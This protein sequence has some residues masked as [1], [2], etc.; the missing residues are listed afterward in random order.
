MRISDWS[1]D[2]CSSDLIE[3][4]F[5]HRLERQRRHAEIAADR[6]PPA[7]FFQEVADERSGRRFS[8]GPGNADIARLGGGAG[9]QLDVAADRADRKSVVEGKS[10]YV[11]VGIGGRRVI[12]KNTNKRP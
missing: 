12:K 5:G 10:V 1:S 2:V 11:R 6:G 9:E 4:V 3:A 7:C 8:V